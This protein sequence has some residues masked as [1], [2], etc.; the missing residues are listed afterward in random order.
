MVKNQLIVKW[1]CIFFLFFMVIKC[2]R[3]F[4]NSAD[5]CAFAILEGEGLNSEDLKKLNVGL[6]SREE[7]DRIIRVR[8]E[9]TIGICILSFIKR[10]KNQNF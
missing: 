1:V 3:Q 2:Q 10:E 4:G 7:Y 6:I 9:S 5:L 8:N